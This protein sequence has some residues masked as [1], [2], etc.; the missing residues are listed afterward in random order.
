MSHLRREDGCQINYI[1]EENIS[2]NVE[3]NFTQP[4]THAWTHWENL[5]HVLQRYQ[6]LKLKV[7]WKKGMP[8]A[9][10]TSD[11]TNESKEAK[12]L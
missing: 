2:F 1:E 8:I 4:S 12:D 5:W 9:G 3:V 7:L 6:R 10:F 11:R